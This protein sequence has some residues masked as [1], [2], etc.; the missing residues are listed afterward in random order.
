ME[1][2]QEMFRVMTR[3]TPQSVR[4]L[5][6][7]FQVMRNHAKGNAQKEVVK[8]QEFIQAKELRTKLGRETSP[9][10]EKEFLA[11]SASKRNDLINNL[12]SRV[13]EMQYEGGEKPL[14]VLLNDGKTIAEPQLLDEAVNMAQLKNVLT[15]YDLKF[16]VKKAPDGKNELYFFAKDKAVFQSAMDKA[17]TDI[18]KNPSIV[19]AP[20]LTAEI[21]K[22]RAVEKTNIQTHNLQKQASKGKE[23]A[24]SI[25]PFEKGV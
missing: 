24:K 6:R 15:E 5:I 9:E 16:H 7:M 8:K 23:V 19:S 18:S 11:M 22:A 4:Q 1:E 25:N 17:I 12:K 10:M 13:H 20:A 2:Q 21:Q 3:D 14:K